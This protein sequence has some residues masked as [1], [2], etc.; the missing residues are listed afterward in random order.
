[1]QSVDVV[2]IGS[3]VIGASVAYHLAARGCSNILVIDSGS[4]PGTGSTG[5]ATGGFRAQFSSETN[6]RLSLLSREKLR[7]FPEECGVDSGY[8]PYGY[9]FVTHQQ[10]VLDAL[11]AAQK[12]QRAAGL[13]EVEA[14]S[15]TEIRQINP[16]IDTEDL[17]GGV[18]CPTDGFIRPMALMHGYMERA[19]ELGVR[20][21][22]GT[23]CTSFQMDASRITAVCT[24][25][26]TI[27]AGC[28]VNAAGA[29]AASVARYA[30][31]DLPVTPLR[32]Q[33]ALTAPCDL[34]PEQMPMTVFADDGFHLRV[35]DGR[36]LLAW[37]DQPATADRFDTTVSN[38]WVEQV[39]RRA[40]RSVPCLART[41]IDRQ[42]CWA[43][44]YEMSPD[45]HA[46]LGPAPGVENFYLV[47]GSSGHG[48]MHAPALGQLL[49]EI[50]L[51][52]QASTLDTY[53]LRPSR[54]AE[55]QPNSTLE[56]L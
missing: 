28:V 24:P 16:A 50:M 45:K 40:H 29:W 5:S 53:A 46:L 3:G 19:K 42:H 6:V 44:L 11:L 14:V 2:I 7:R 39:T 8:R 36:I 20:F 48:V 26:A 37:P 49:A 30:G 35:R 43:G 47:N 9:L 38:L 21:A 25:S 34:L 1:M 22:C 4:E 23:S 31:I 17:L 15:P 54:F 55:G 52:G 18:F 10:M 33:V 12:I 51:D 13:H 27:A 56:L 41:I 32:R